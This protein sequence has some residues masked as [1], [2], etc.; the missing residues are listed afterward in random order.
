MKKEK[1]LKDNIYFMLKAQLALESYEDD[2][3]I[4]VPVIQE[5]YSKHKE[6][7]NLRSSLNIEKQLSLSN[8]IIE[9]YNEAFD[10]VGRDNFVFYED[11]DINYIWRNVK[12]NG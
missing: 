5:A 12:N 2:N 4:E 6:F 9:K 10:H 1:K 8:D 3:N 7:R 11:G